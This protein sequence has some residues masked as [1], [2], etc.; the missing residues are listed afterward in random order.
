MA[1]LLVVAVANAVTGADAVAVCGAEAS[2]LPFFTAAWR[3]RILFSVSRWSVGRVPVLVPAFF[4]GCGGR[5][6]GQ[7]GLDL[8]ILLCGGGG[9]LVQRSVDG[10]VCRREGIKLAVQ[11]LQNP[12]RVPSVASGIG[13][14]GHNAMESQSRGGGSE[15]VRSVAGSGGLAI[16]VQ[17]EGL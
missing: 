13:E 17:L 2:H 6:V 4:S 1:V 12:V 9:G 15:H 7:R 8:L 11:Q 16:E 10:G 5:E 3:I 14:V